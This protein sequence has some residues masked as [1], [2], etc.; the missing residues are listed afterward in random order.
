MEGFQGPQNPLKVTCPQWGEAGGWARQ[1]SFTG[2]LSQAHSDHT[3]GD[4]LS[5]LFSAPGVWS[6][7]SSLCRARLSL[8]SSFLDL[9]LLSVPLPCLSHV[10][11]KG[12]S[13]GRFRC[14]GKAC[15]D[16][17]PGLSSLSWGLFKLEGFVGI[18][19]RLCSCISNHALVA[20]RCAPYPFPFL[21]PS[22]SLISCEM[23]QPPITPTLLLSQQSNPAHLLT[24]SGGQ[25]CPDTQRSA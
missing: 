21:Q 25:T 22:H 5:C 18:S 24:F 2:G 1:G 6:Q 17:R 16:L 9:W 23:T 8:L 4:L 15:Y 7:I 10:G 13:V 11:G 3:P 19:E 12:R 14:A 20:I